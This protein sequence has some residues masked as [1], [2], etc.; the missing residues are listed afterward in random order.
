VRA[1]VGFVPGRAL[2]L[3][4]G[5]ME[6]RRYVYRNR[7]LAELGFDPYTDLIETTQGT[8][9]WNPKGPSF[10]ELRAWALKYFESRREDGTSSETSRAQ[11]G[12]ENRFLRGN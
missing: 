11:A 5:E 2:H 12:S 9:A 6:D 7:E 4:H 1:Q 3:W 8:W 10:P